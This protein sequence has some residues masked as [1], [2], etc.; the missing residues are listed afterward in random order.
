LGLDVPAL[1]LVDE[2]KFSA[3]VAPTMVAYLLPVSERGPPTA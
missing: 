1:G 3:P 2:L